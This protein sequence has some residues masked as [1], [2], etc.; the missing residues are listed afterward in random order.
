MLVP[1]I[2]LIQ[3]GDQA[4]ADRY[5]Y[6]PMI[7][8][9]IIISWGGADLLKNP[10]Y[11][12]AILTSAAIV[13]ISVLSVL[14]HIQQGYWRDSF[15]LFGHALEVT[16]DNYVAHFSIADPLRAIGKTKEA[17]DHNR[18]CIEIEPTYTRGHNSLGQGLLETGDIDGAIKSF[19]K[20]VEL[21]PGAMEPRTNLGIALKA[22]GNYPQAIEQFTIV[23]QMYDLILV[24][25]H[26]AE[27]ILMAGR[28]QD[29]AQEYTKIL[30][31]NPYIPTSHNGLA[32]A[33]YQ[34][35]RIDKAIEHLQIALKIAPDYIDAN[36]NLQ[37][38]LQQRAKQTPDANSSGKPF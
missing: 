24:R 28:P 12:K 1:V 6:T 4:Y 14:T 33:F 32:V 17:I 29:S 31:A 27:A 5:T 2:G 3:V 26:R 20:A 36:N 19:K 13:I 37:F 16:K 9:F 21:A 38:M 15:K 23:L 8:L 7:G 10:K 35:G 25:E 18:R 11:R 22:Q 34:L 30:N